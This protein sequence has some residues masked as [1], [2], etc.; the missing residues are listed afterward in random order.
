MSEIITD[1]KNVIA[2]GI[3]FSLAD[4]SNAISFDFENK[5]YT[6]RLVFTT[7]EDKGPYI[8]WVGVD[9]ST[10]EITFRNF[11][12]PAGVRN[13]D[14]MELGSIGSKRLMMNVNVTKIGSSRRVVIYSV[15]LGDK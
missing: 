7:S 12:D 8:S 1:G 2:S 11:D 13:S 9:T 14:L 15:Y 3:F 10:L 4:G 6:L 5:K